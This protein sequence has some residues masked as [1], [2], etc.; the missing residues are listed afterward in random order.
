MSKKELTAREMFEDIDYEL[1][2]TRYVTIVRYRRCACGGEYT[3]V[4]D[5][6]TMPFG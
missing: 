2:D 3:K 6:S 4:I 5:F 1:V